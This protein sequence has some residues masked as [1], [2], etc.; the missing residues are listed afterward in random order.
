MTYSEIQQGI[1]YW[2][3]KV[4]IYDSRCDFYIAR[5]F[6]YK[7]QLHLWYHNSEDEKR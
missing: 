2:N 5:F 4:S 3:N 6:W 7:A 1:N